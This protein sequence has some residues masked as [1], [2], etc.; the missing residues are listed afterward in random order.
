MIGAIAGDIIGSVHERSNTKRTDF[1]LF[2]KK[3][4]FTDDT[5]MS[6]AIAD[7]IL[8]QENYAIKL[9]EY[10][11]TYPK[12]GYG[13][14]FRKWLKSSNSEPYNSFGNGSAMRV[15]PVGFAFNSL[16]DVLHEAKKSAEVTHN[17]PEGIKGAQAVA[18]AIFLARQNN[19]K[20]L[21]KNYIE[22][23]FN[24]NLDR[25][26]NEIRKDYSF[27]VTCQGSVPEAIISFF[28]STDLESAIRIGISLGGD[29]DTI[30][31]M[32]GSIAQAYYKQIPAFII[33]KVKTI[34]HEDLF[35]IVNKFNERFL[36]DFEII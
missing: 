35:I 4:T 20:K 15:S 22:K 28:E 10:G 27:D 26:I 5:V 11:R 24:Y 6:V 9:K 23:E 1:K 19:D 12:R 8:N 18:S 29:A 2:V 3:C 34:L 14:Y 30:A 21:I 31:C 7:A 25:K 13:G 16:K 36:V 33:E 32:A 17:H